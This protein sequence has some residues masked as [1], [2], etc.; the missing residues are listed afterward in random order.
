MYTIAAGARQD[1]R[2]ALDA[3]DSLAEQERYRNNAN[4]QL[5][6][7]EDAKKKNAIGTVGGMVAAEGVKSAL[8]TGA[9]ETVA[10]EAAGSAATSALGTGAGAGAATGATA[11][12]TAGATTAASTTAAAGAGGGGATAALAAIPGWGWMALGGMALLS[13]A[14]VFD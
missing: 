6:E 1:K 9:A 12:A 10:A 13:S 11:G 4:E 14:G 7:A 8:A 2:T 5:A 3:F